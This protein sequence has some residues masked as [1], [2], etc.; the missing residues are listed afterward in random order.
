MDLKKQKV[1]IITDWL[2]TRGGAERVIFS[3]KSLF[4]QAVI[5]TSVY[6]E[7]NFPELKNSEI[8]TTCLQK[9]PPFFRRKHQFLLPFFPRAFANLDLSEFDLIISSSSSG[10]SK[11]VH[12]SRENQVHICYC[13]TPNRFLYHAREEYVKNFPIPWWGRW[14]RYFLPMILDWLTKIDQ[15]SA[16]KVDYWV[17]N[18]DFVARRIQKYYHSNSETIYPGVETA[19]FQKAF[20]AKASAERGDN[21]Y[22]LAVG[23][24]IPYKKFDL[25]VETF[26]KNGLPLKL[27]GKGPELTKCQNLAKNLK[28]DNIEFL[29][30]VPDEDLPQLYAQAGA[31]LFPAE[32]DFGLTPIEAMSAG[33]PVIFY[34]RGGASES[35]GEWGIPFEAQTVE[36]L[37][38]AI[39]KFQNQ[40][41][42][43]HK[44]KSRGISFDEKIFR[45]KLKKFLENLGTVNS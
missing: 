16:K 44:I 28:A 22:F 19:E 31:F 39:E 26:A 43:L 6:S 23:R 24:F 20:Q 32:E 14:I 5:F 10:F 1:A 8:R 11:C 29:G 45:E 38:S 42:D 13:H 40:K 21:D 30:F 2:T 36:S 35:V 7:K 9:L 12:K 3:L 25:L 17:A 37:Q 15:K 34:N 33:C 41:I 18:S 4:P 27:V